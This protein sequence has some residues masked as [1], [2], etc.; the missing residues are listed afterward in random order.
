MSPNRHVYPR[1]PKVLPGE[2]KHIKRRVSAILN[3]DKFF[4]RMKS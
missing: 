1:I 4:S 2:N 3:N